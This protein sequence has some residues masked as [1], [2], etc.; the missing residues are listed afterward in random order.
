M[1]F[2]SDP[3]NNM[4]DTKLHDFHP[5]FFHFFQPLSITETDPIVNAVIC[6]QNAVK[7]P[8]IYFLCHFLNRHMNFTDYFA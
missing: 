5:I 6:K 7:Y 1:R 3:F 2:P 4:C 8:N